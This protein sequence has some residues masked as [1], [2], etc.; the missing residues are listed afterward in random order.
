MKEHSRPE[1]NAMNPAIAFHDLFALKLTP[2]SEY[3]N[4]LQTFYSREIILTDR[5]DNV[6]RIHL[7]APFRHALTLATEQTTEPQGETK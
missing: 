2:V 5:D 1:I 7:F 6:Y 3:Q 4:G